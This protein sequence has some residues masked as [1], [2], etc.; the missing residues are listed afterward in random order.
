[1]ASIRRE[2]DVVQYLQECRRPQVQL[3]I[4]EFS[5]MGPSKSSQ[6]PFNFDSEILKGSWEKIW[7]PMI[8]CA[9]ATPAPRVYIKGICEVFPAQ[10]RYNKAHISGF[11]LNKHSHAL[12]CAQISHF[13]SSNSFHAQHDKLGLLSMANAGRNTNGSQF[14]ICTSTP[15]HLNGKHVVFGECLTDA[16]YKIMDAVQRVKVGDGD[17][18]VKVG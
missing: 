8:F 9:S 12:S 13:F 4:L 1:M 5:S 14:F 11:L 2:C 17:K 3:F 18:P 10:R 16:D 7:D 15:A 6:D